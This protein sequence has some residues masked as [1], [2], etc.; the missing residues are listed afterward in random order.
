MLVTLVHVHV[1]PD[2]VSDF[3]EATR[4]NHAGAV[5]EPGCLRFDVLQAP[6]D[7]TRFVLYEAY[8]DAAAAAAH[9]ETAHYL[10]WRAVVAGWMAEPRRAEPFSG[11]LPDFP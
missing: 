2:H 8:R 5:A 10:A 3:I 1:L 4:P 6:D 7:P 9:K 11:L